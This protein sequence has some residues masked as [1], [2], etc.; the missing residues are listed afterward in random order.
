MRSAFC[1]ALWMQSGAAQNVMTTFAGTEYVFPSVSQPALRAPIGNVS[2]VLWEPRIGVLIAD[3]DHSIVLKVS[4]DG[5]VSVF[6][7]I[8]IGGFSGDGGPATLAA[9]RGPRFLARDKDGNVYIADE[10]NGRIRKVDRDGII[11]TVAG[12]GVYGFSGDGGPAT[13]A[14]MR[15]PTGVAVDGQGNLFIADQYNHR[16]RRVDALTGIITTI[17]GD[18]QERFFGDN[19]PAASA[20]VFYPRGLAFDSQGNLYIADQYNHRVRRIDRDGR[21]TTYAGNGSPR[22]AGDGGPATEASI[23]Y[24][25]EVAFDS[26]D[27]LYIADKENNVV[28]RVTRAGVMST[29]AGVNRRGFDGDG[30]PATR[31]SLTRPQ[32]VDADDQGN[33]FITDSDNNRLRRVSRDGTIT[34][35]AGSGANRYSGDG[36]LATS[37]VINQP[38]DTLI[39]AAGNLI[40]SDR[41]ARVIRKIDRNQVISTVA[42]TGDVGTSG[43]NGPA[44]QMRMAYPLG[45]AMDAAGNLYIADGLGQT[46]RR[47]TPQGTVEL[48]A[49]DPG[50]FGFSAEGGPRRSAVFNSPTGIAFDGAGN[51]YVADL[52][53]HRVRRIATDGS[54]RTVAGTGTPGFS[55]DGGP[56]TSAEIS[57][58]SDVAVDPAGNLYIADRNNNRIRMVTPAGVIRTVVGDGT[59]GSEG[60]GGPAARARLWYPVTLTYHGGNLYIGDHYNHRVRRVLA[61]GNIETVAGSGR[62]GFN[63]DG[64]LAVDSD[65]FRPAGVAVDSA[66]DLYIADSLNHRIRRVLSRT[67]TIEVSAANISFA[68]QEGELSQGRVLRLASSVPGVS[69]TASASEPWLKV[70]PASGQLPADLRL[71]ADASSLAA[72]SFTANVVVDVPRANPSR[73]TIPVTITVTRSLPAQLDLPVSALTFSLRQGDPAARRVVPVSNGGG[74]TLEF[75]ANTEV[76]SGAGWLTANP[77]SGRATISAPMDVEV[78][79]SADGLA[80]GTYSGRVIVEGAGTSRTVDVTLTVAPAAE[81]KI[82]LS[83]VGLAF[84]AA[85]GGGIPLTQPIGVLNVGEGSMT[86]Q[87]RSSTLG[88]GSGWLKIGTTS[89]TVA[90]A[91]L[92]VN[93]SEVSID[94]RGLA[95]GDY[96]GQVEFTAQ[97]INSP[98]L[99]SV[100]LRVLP[101][102]ADPGPEIQ[103]TTLV[104]TGVQGQSPAAQTV[105]IANRRPQTIDYDSFGGPF[106]GGQWFSHLPLNGALVPGTP[107]KVVVQP[108]FSKLAPGVQT[109][110]VTLTFPRG[111]STPL[112]VNVVSVVAEPGSGPAKDDRRFAASCRRP[113]LQ[114]QT[115]SLFA[116]GFVSTIGEP[117]NL[118]VKVV[119][120]CGTPLTPESGASS[121]VTASFS[122][123]DRDVEL[124]HLGDGVWTAT[125]HPTQGTAGPLAIR[126]LASYRQGLLRQEGAARL[127]GALRTASATPRLVPRGLVHSASFERGPV[128]PG[129]LI[130]IFGA[131][132]ASAPAVVDTPSL[133]LSFNGVEVLMAGKPLPIRYADGQQINAQIPLDIVPNTQ[134]QIVV[135]TNG[136]LSVPEEFTVAVGEPGIFTKDQS[137]RGQG[138]V[139]KPD[140]V[141]PAEP[142]TPAIA[143]EALVIYCTGLGA[144]DTLVG[145]GQP[146]PSSPVART[147]APVAVR[148]G[149][150]DAA[151]LFAGLTPGFVGLY[152]VN[153]IMPTG[154][155]SGDAVPVVVSAQG[156]SSPDYV[157]MAVE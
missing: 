62:G 2:G 108:D 146:A 137:G 150:V 112:S 128:A 3:F 58:P 125:W 156:R 29:V 77:A 73:R 97:A 66:G 101:Q 122:N 151:V 13:G 153:V 132:F 82:L 7:G 22:F 21:M 11:T 135:K 37:A 84:T 40:F 43:D 98:Q 74:G 120:E 57:G 95:P 56:A 157:T 105:Q 54:V 39:D 52:D 32:G 18:G 64:G 65:M 155:A 140:G 34:T 36:R 121:N 138:W 114:V 143:G 41:E 81:R 55:G 79:A 131:N 89:G 71:E 154:V 60:D 44:V 17:A 20:S 30:G 104:F 4:T 6:A 70:S 24:P 31:A 133:P 46:I 106:R 67:P 94:H 126:V 92:D 149:G 27:N 76:D 124:N 118:T 35:L 1:L 113:N 111:D 48:F 78:V 119:D 115:T 15:F 110:A 47:V 72:G 102:G 45:L 96:Y 109:G 80:P 53:N 42:G 5:N 23:S 100:L 144:L 134:Q 123:G 59:A 148:I 19:G 117:T 38:W 75:T 85:A 83:Q 93:F 116:N 136:A 107:Q 49:G 90:R 145:P 69:Y 88:G 14:A 63:G 99:V 152:Q 16:I 25:G 10:G 139:M 147:L 12:S 86:W 87:A 8:G 130:S 50:R 26:E 51:L 142:G 9:I 103:P 127:S 68:L 61:N 33:L 28:R 141:T 129:S 91:K